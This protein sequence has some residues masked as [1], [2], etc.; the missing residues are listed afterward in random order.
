MTTL[1]KAWFIATLVPCFCL[2]TGL[3]MYGAAERIYCNL[4]KKKGEVR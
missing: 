2:V 4:R 1:K 3:C